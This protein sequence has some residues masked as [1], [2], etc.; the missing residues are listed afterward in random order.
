M[1]NLLDSDI[2]LIALDKFAHN[3]KY[4]L[5]DNWQNQVDELCDY[6]ESH[7]EG[8][9]K[10]VAVGHSFG[11]VISFMACCQRPE[12]F[13]GLIMLDP[14]L[15]SGLPRYLFRFAK[16]TKLID[17]LTPAGITK[18][19]KRAF[20]HDQDLIAYFS[21]KSL[22]KNFEL[23]CVQDYVNAVIEQQDNTLR[24]HFDVETEV[25]IFRTIPHNLPSYNGKLKLPAYLI[26]GSLTEV[27]VPVLRNPFL[28]Q[29]PSI[30]HIELDGGGHMF[31]LEKCSQT[32]NLI[33]RLLREIV[34]N[35]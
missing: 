5:N 30:E 24:L 31:P 20:A 2:D 13:K 12:L 29:H 14:P 28:K 21:K 32:A 27:C 23:E 25:N 8:S 11:A 33:N 9:E 26:T 7:K 3:P 15:V 19:R 16:K 22:F 6:V 1:F 17:R 4:P 18:Q 10:Y 35:D 34:A